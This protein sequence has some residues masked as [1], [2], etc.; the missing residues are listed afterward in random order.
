M[1]TFTH[2][3]AETIAQASRL[4][5]KYRGKAVLNA[6]GTDVLAVLKDKILPDYPQ[7]IIN[8]KSIAG[9]NYVKEDGSGL[10]I[11]ALTRL[12][13]IETSETIRTHYPIL[14]EAAAAVATPNVRNMC[15]IGG[16]LAQHI[17]CWYYRYPR[18]IGGPIACLR[19]GGKLCNA[20]VGDNRYHSIFGAAA[21][22]PHPCSLQ[23]PAH[24]DIA[25][26]LE[27]IRN[28]DLLGAARMLLDYNPLPAVTGRVCPAFCETGCNRT[29]FDEA[30]AIRCIE[31]SMGDFVL[32]RA[33]DMYRHPETEREI[34]IAIVGSG[35]A[36][37]A[38]A[39]YLRRCGYR[40]TVFER[41]PEPGGMLLY[42]IPAYRLPKQVVRK[43][44]AALKG[45]GITFEVGV[46]V[47]QD[48][49]LSG[50]K[51]LFSA[52]F[53]AGGTWESLR[54]GIPGEDN[55]NVIQALDYLK[56][57]NSGEN[58][59]PGQR[60]IVIGGGSVAI[61]AARVAK[62]SGVRG[63]H[64]VCL[65]CR[66]LQ[67][68]DRML[69][70]DGEILD[71]EEEGVVIHA[72]LGVKEI[73]TSGGRAVGL[74]TVR[75][76][77]V[78]DPDGTF[79]PCYGVS[80]DALRLE[81]DTI[82]VAI[83]QTADRSLDS[84]DIEYSGKG[85]IMVNERA[86]KAGSS[87]VFAGGDIVTGP[88]TVAQA[89]ASGREAARSID[90]SLC[91][92]RPEVE[93]RK[94]ERAL[95]TPYFNE[96]A[97]LRLKQ[98]PAGERI[99]STDTEDMPGATMS[100]IERETHRCFNCGC[101]AV[102]PSDIGVSLIAL[103]AKIKTTKRTI[104]AERLFVVS[105][106][107][108]TILDADELITG[109]TIPRPAKDTRQTYVKF[110]IR[111]PIDFAIASVA[112]VTR[113]E[114]DVFKGVRIV[115]G[116]VAPV[117]VRASAAEKL[118]EGKGI[119]EDAGTDRADRAAETALAYAK[120]LSMNAYKMDIAKSLIARA[121]RSISTVDGMRKR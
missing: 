14:A 69:A 116:G 62:R 89:I 39:Y 59:Q 2:F 101:V 68:K 5:K 105:A 120:A 22:D 6:G 52:V 92:R 20:L 86:L 49:T 87:R 103:G 76:L 13:Q 28:N 71:A 48:V 117:P 109:I 102:S 114:E 40:V 23:C 64:L 33:A 38:A 30:V 9:L 47:G 96:A 29:E 4:L 72:S 46:N 83:G 65:E 53:F 84:P 121:I 73:I 82:I 79:N 27:K 88:S 17:R 45:M 43:Q 106:T 55:E 111:K 93:K 1:K 70:Q 21:I 12:S 119:V 112:A 54:L 90:L 51:E 80:A 66:D 77:S 18:Q 8:I 85:T 24:T 36:G 108:S 50:L 94:K 32:E 107:Q 78:R 11:G 15:T 7:A 35:P 91:N 56:R 37:L 19:K 63:V 100:E 42:G 61:D 95:V 74:K 104:D 26:Y 60:V 25:S 97:R 67:S 16:N 99:K 58:V 34:A 81:A 3:N 115:L 31:R 98:Q 113:I 118:L 10:E 44:V 57:V 41:L 110:T 75:C